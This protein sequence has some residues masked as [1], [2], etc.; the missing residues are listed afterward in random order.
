MA[1]R[2]A[3][4]ILAGAHSNEVVMA[5]SPSKDGRIGALATP[6]GKDA[7][8]LGR[9]DGVEGLGELFEYR[10]EALST[11]ENIDFNQLIG[12]NLSIHLKT[13][14]DVGRDFSGVLVEARWTG[15][16]GALYIYRLVL[17]PWLW[18]LSRTSD[19]RIFSSMKVTDIIVKVFQERGFTDFR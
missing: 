12:L 10:I 14:D 4:R 6:L 18:L 5:D 13:V 8:L 11:Q 17:K 19:C 1:Y 15:K 7:L 9:F 2:Q 3:G 16:R